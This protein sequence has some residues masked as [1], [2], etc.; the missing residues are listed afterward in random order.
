MIIK[1]LHLKNFG[2]FSGRT[3]SFTPGINLIYGANEAG[4]TTIYHAVGAM[5][6]GMERKKGRAARNDTYTTYQPWENKTWYEGTMKFETGGKCFCIERNFYQGERSVRLFCETDGE[7]LSVEQ[8]DLQML[9]GETSEGLFFNTAAAGQLKMKP[10]EI[11]YNYLDQYIT[12]LWETEGHGSD[13]SKAL[14]ILENKKKTLERQK[15]VQRQM[16]ESQIAQNEDRT[17]MVEKDLRDFQQQ[18]DH[19]KQQRARL[20]QEKTEKKRG[21]LARF[22][23]WLLGLFRREITDLREQQNLEERRKLKEKETFLLDLLGEK[24]SRREE[25]ILEKE[26]FYRQLHEIS[27]SDEITAVEMAMERIRSLSGDGK[28]EIMNRL[29]AKAS[30]VL[31]CMTEG[32]YKKVFFSREQEPEVWDG[33]RKL[34]MFQVSTGCQDQIY[35]AVR[36]ALQDLFFEDETMPLMFDDAFVYFD[37]ERLER[38]LG[39]L[40][41]LGRQ[42]LIFTCHCREIQILE[43]S[44]ISFG[45]IMLK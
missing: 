38:I 10:Q 33:S 8:G 40:S 29:Q 15:K 36:I 16:I 30:A 17:D 7:E 2:K 23:R 6:F 44:G 31:N 24:E 4:K 35:L 21:F 41:G 32:K 34:S 19:L 22:F 11:V 26:E 28:E 43:K 18:L 5:L 45:K 25:L 37:E 27:K 20:K 42:V 3:F 12:G 9:L 39:Y 13:F 1:E 14:E